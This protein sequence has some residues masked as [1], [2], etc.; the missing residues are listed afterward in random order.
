MMGNLGWA[1]APG[2]ENVDI[3]DRFNGVPPPKRLPIG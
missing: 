1:P 2:I 3:F